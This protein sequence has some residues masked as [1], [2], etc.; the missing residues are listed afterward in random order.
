[1]TRELYAELREGLGIIE[2]KTE[3]SLVW[4][5]TLNTMLKGTVPDAMLEAQFGHSKD[6]NRSHYTDTAMPADVA[7]AAIARI[8]RD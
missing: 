1:M 2:F 5:A 7:R 3:R 4:R 6:V 8:S